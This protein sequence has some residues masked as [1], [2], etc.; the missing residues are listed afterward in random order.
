MRGY[1][2]IRK[3]AFDILRNQ[4]PKNL[5]YH[6]MSHTLD[7]LNVC[8]GYIRRGKITAETGKLLRLS[9][10]LH[11]IGFSVSYDRHEDNGAEMA[12]KLLRGY[13]VA[14]SQIRTIQNLI[15]ATKVPHVP[16]SELQKIICDADLDYL[17]RD[18]YPEISENLYRELKAY[19]KI[20]D[21]SNWL[22]MQIRFL[23]AHNYHT[24]YAK[25]Y[26]EPGKQ[27]RIEEL[28]RKLK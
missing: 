5:Y 22:K 2:R 24:S 20:N 21:R 11:D 9:A 16:Q 8:N 7:V 1:Y 27:R 6:G 28:R 4:L 3:E 10:I 12:G 18:D 14:Q 25:K 26:R 15:L 19:K 23:D 13:Q 17:G